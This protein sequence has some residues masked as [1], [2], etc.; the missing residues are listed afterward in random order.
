MGERLQRRLIGFFE[1]AVERRKGLESV[2]RE[3]LTLVVEAPTEIFA[4]ELWRPVIPLLP[5]TAQEAEPLFPF[6][7]SFFENLGFSP[8]FESRHLFRCHEKVFER[9]PAFLREQD[10]SGL[11]PLQLE[12]PLLS[13]DLLSY[14]SKLF[15][16]VERQRLPRG[17]LELLSLHCFDSKARERLDSEKFLKRIMRLCLRLVEEKNLELLMP[18]LHVLAKLTYADSSAQRCFF[19][20]NGKKLLSR[21]LA[22]ELPVDSDALDGLFCAAI[23]CCADND[24]QLHVWAADLIVPLAELVEQP[25]ALKLLAELTHNCEEI[26]RDLHGRP[27]LMRRVQESVLRADRRLPESLVLLVSGLELL[28]ELLSFNH[29]SNATIQN[30]LINFISPTF[31]TQLIE[32]TT[33]RADEAAGLAVAIFNA[34]GRV[35]WK[36]AS[37]EEA[38]VEIAE[39]LCLYKKVVRSALKFFAGSS[40]EIVHSKKTVNRLKQFSFFVFLNYDYNSEL[41]LFALQLTVSLA[42]NEDTIQGTVP[43]FPFAKLLDIARNSAASPLQRRLSLKALCLA[44]NTPEGSALLAQA[45]ER[46]EGFTKAAAVFESL[47]GFEEC[48]K[49]TLLLVA[50]LARGSEQFEAELTRDPLRARLGEIVRDT[51]QPG[52]PLAEAVAQLP[53]ELFLL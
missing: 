25:L 6:L 2:W 31:L 3:V 14:A 29:S 53:L 36:N 10:L 30:A 37:G 34:L 22:L 39:K 38:L 26:I 52:S 33:T 23:N 43:V 46:G 50:L 28:T 35:E 15:F 13:G 51:G 24:F 32:L 4:E 49:E 11:P 8:C 42:Y 20:K 1:E 16:A 12:N 17:L 47:L 44:A 27:T 21:A 48:L 19:L 40:T 5:V 9:S 45:V 18:A 41:T 7:L